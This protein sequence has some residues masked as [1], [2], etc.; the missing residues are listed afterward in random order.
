[1][2]IKCL[3][4]AHWSD[5]QKNSEAI[6]KPI[7]LEETAF[8]ILLLLLRDITFEKIILLYKIRKPLESK[9]DL[10]KNLKTESKT[11]E[12]NVLP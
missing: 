2:E 6:I 8:R 12:D 3:R 1:M 4:Q 11:Q 7:Q 9:R 10:L 5:L